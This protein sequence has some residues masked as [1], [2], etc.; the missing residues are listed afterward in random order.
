MGSWATGSYG[1]P[2]LSQRNNEFL[3]CIMRRLMWGSRTWGI[4]GS[5]WHQFVQNC[6]FQLQF[7]F[8][9]P[10]PS[11]PPHCLYRTVI[12]SCSQN[13]QGVSA[14]CSIT[15]ARSFSPLT[16]S[17]SLCR[18]H[19]KW[20]RMKHVCNLFKDSALRMG[21]PA[22]EHFRKR[23]SLVRLIQKRREAK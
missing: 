9:M 11:V 22:G 17:L 20:R 2:P 21:C 3:Q 7:L 13:Q 12:L 1:E 19:T 4:S 5:Y 14:H 8:F 6:F 23:K 18:K 15:R 16:Q 10:S